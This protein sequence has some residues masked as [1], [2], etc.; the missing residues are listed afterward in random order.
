MHARCVGRYGRFCFFSP[1][2]RCLQAPFSAPTLNT[3][4]VAVRPSF[5]MFFPTKIHARTD[6]CLPFCSVCFVA[7]VCCGW[8]VWVIRR[9]VNADLFRAADLS[10]SVEGLPLNQPLSSLPVASASRFSAIDSAFSSSIVGLHTA[11]PLGDVVSARVQTWYN[12]Q[13]I[14]VLDVDGFWFPA[15]VFSFF[16]F[17]EI[18]RDTDRLVASGLLVTHSRGRWWPPFGLPRPLELC[19]ACAYITLSSVRLHP[20]VLFV[21]QLVN[22]HCMA[23]HDTTR[24][25]MT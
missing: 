12:R 14:D 5:R 25:G 22:W 19:S 18:P 10:F 17:Y 24:H 21:V 16:F 11:L 1:L 20:V 4:Q 13:Q 23:W 2:D 15:R 8:P 6:T 9:A 3:V 7:T